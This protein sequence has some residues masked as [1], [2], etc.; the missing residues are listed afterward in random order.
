MEKLDDWPHEW[1]KVLLCTMHWEYNGN[2]QTFYEKTLLHR[3]QKLENEWIGCFY[4]LEISHFG[5]M[6]PKK[7]HL[8]YGTRSEGELICQLEK[9]GRWFLF[10][11]GK[12]DSDYCSTC[13]GKTESSCTVIECASLHDLVWSALGEYDRYLL[14]IP[15]EF[16][17]FQ[18]FRKSISRTQLKKK[19]FG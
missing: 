7:P 17:D 13:D 1:K 12:I 14:D 3:L 10:K 19:L 5:K 4:N 11:D 9:G 18:E 2:C 15:C 16:Q 8:L 6:E